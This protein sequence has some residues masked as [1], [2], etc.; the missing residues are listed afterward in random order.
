MGRHGKHWS[1]E[2]RIQLNWMMYVWQDP[3]KTRESLA[4]S[5]QGAAVLTQI[6]SIPL[7]SWR[8]SFTSPSTPTRRTSSRVWAS[9]RS[10]TCS[11]AASSLR[12][13]CPTAGSAPPTSRVRTCPWPWRARPHAYS[14]STPVRERH[15]HTYTLHTV[16]CTFCTQ[17]GVDAMDI[18]VM[19]IRPHV[20][21]VK[22]VSSKRLGICPKFEQI[23]AILCLICFGIK[24]H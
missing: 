24:W 17:C 8:T 11:A 13:C 19:F 16:T 7:R 5:L 22:L 1:T 2:S 15:T 4:V 6:T 14:T 9:W 20:I 23:R 12:C 3:I 10:G 18:T 21:K